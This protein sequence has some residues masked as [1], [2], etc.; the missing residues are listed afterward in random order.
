MH[1]EPH[2]GPMVVAGLCVF[3]SR[4]AAQTCTSCGRLVCR[5]HLIVGPAPVCIACARG[6]GTPVRTSLP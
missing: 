3:C 6:R 4:P 2:P 1:V 5:D